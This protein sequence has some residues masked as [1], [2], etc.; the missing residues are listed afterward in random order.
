MYYTK[1]IIIDTIKNKLNK[2]KDD[3]DIH[4]YNRTKDK[5]IEN[6]S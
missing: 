1:K 4:K 5:K 6:R 2:E 3:Y